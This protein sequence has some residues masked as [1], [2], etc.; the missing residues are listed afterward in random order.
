MAPILSVIVLNYNRIEYSRQTI[1][2]ILKITT[3]PIELILVD[4]GS[5]KLLRDYLSSIKNKAQ[6]PVK[7][8]FSKRNLGISG[9]RN[10]GAIASNP[11]SK[12]LLFVDDDIL[13]PQDYDK[14]II[15]AVG[16]IKNVGIVGCCVEGQEYPI[17]EIDGV[18]VRTK[19]GNINGGCM[20]FS[21]SVWKK[22]GYFQTN[23]GQY[24]GDDIDMDFRTMRLGLI[25]VYIAPYGIHLDGG[26]EIQKYNEFKK[27]THKDTS[28]QNKI[29]ENNIKEYVINKNYHVP[30]VVT[31]P[32]VSNFNKFGGDVTDLVKEKRAI[33]VTAVAND[34][35]RAV[36][37][38]AETQKQ[39]VAAWAHI[40]VGVGLDKKSE[41]V[42]VDVAKRRKDTYFVSHGGT[43]P[44]IYNDILFNFIPSQFPCAEFIIFVEQSDTLDSSGVRDIVQTFDSNQL[45]GGIYSGF[46]V[47]DQN[48]A[49][50]NR[51][52]KKAVYLRNQFNPEGQDTLRKI[53]LTSNPFAHVNAFRIEYLQAFGGFNEKISDWA[54]YYVYGAMLDK[55]MVVKIDKVL[56]SSGMD[57]TA[58]FR[59]NDVDSRNKSLRII[60]KEFRDKFLEKK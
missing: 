39:D 11:K 7:C 21:R 53:F 58:P 8:V 18:S 27:L 59:N 60:S 17:K 3:F 41:D 6:F 12:A 10:R 36:R 54:E 52:V 56:Y 49:T 26:K 13:L 32:S 40:V 47:V 34:S 51:N 45:V 22:I 57:M 23:F 43:K 20:A 38:I 42:Y 37:A 19:S 14:L 33:I 2:N 30:Y 9:G 31:L 16:K 1:E 55:H 29:F 44:I 5:D 15:E 46:R 48:G 24:F 50:I 28:P 25:N 4:N 35:K